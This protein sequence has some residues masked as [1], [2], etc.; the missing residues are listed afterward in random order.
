MK[1]FIETDTLI[2]RWFADNFNNSVTQF[3]ILFLN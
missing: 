1:R 2:L 3:F